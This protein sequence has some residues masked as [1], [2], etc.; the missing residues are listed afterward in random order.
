[1]LNINT[2]N[3]KYNSNEKIQI[4]NKRMNDSLLQSLN[5]SHILLPKSLSKDEFNN[6]I[7]NITSTTKKPMDIF[8]SKVSQN[9]VNY[10]QKTSQNNSKK[11]PNIIIFNDY[12]KNSNS[13]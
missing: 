9:K 5:R 6:D 11:N 1:M 12:F 8:Y 7:I 2:H 4:Y 13:R 10:F 3:L